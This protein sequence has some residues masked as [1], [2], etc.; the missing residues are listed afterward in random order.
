GVNND[1]GGWKLP[2][3]NSKQSYRDAYRVTARF[4]VWLEKKYDKKLVRKLNTAMR[5]KKYTP[6]F[7]EKET[8]KS[9]DELWQAYASEPSIE[10]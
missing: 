7:W 2:E 9:I 10:G 3:Y 5:E 1:K 6:E 4:F 8:G